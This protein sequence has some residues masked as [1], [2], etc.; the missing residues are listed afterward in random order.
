[1][2]TY[3]CCWPIGADIAGAI[4]FWPMEAG[5]SAPEEPGMPTDEPIGFMPWFMGMP[6]PMCIP[7]FMGM[8]WFTGIPW[9]MPWF[10]GMPWLMGMPWLG[11]PP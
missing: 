3:D 5:I 1:M 4:W 11:P 7:W 9:L 8:P 2:A 10:V 6:W